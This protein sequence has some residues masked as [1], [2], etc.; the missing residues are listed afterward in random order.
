[1]NQIRDDAQLLAEIKQGNEKAFG[2]L[3]QKYQR[4]V[5]NVIYLTLGFRD[6][7]DDLTQEV[8]IRVHRSISKFELDSSL[9]SWIYRIAV[10]ISI[11]E[12]RRRKIRKT[13]SLD[14]FSDGIL[15]SE[16]KGKKAEDPSEHYLSSEKKEVV[17]EAIQKLP[18][19]HKTVI[20]LREYENLS[21]QEIGE[22]LKISIPAVKSRLFRAREE[23][24]ILLKDY[25]EERI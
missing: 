2:E 16:R 19:L 21:Y 17:R 14:F 6:N 1:M 7:V 13:L 4:Q 5:A 22:V 12:I 15:Y 24:R 3:V 8:F 18:Q 20:I 9:F 25:F 23:L 11:D 10:N